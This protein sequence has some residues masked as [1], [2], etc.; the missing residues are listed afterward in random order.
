MGSGAALDSSVD[1]EDHGLIPRICSGIF[2]RVD[3]VSD[4]AHCRCPGSTKPWQELAK[5]N[6]LA[7]IVFVFF[8]VETPKYDNNC[9][10]VF[11]YVHEYHYRTVVIVAVVV[12]GHCVFSARTKS[13]LILCYTAVL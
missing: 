10:C 12:V 5:G 11:M 8:V 4:R 1:P 13:C 9:L 7:T 3:Q 2:E 6:A